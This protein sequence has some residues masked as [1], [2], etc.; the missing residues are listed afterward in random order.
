MYIGF[1]SHINQSPLNFLFISS[2][3]KFL[4]LFSTSF[5]FDSW[6]GSSLNILSKWTN[7]L[8][9]SYLLH[10]CKSVVFSSK[11]IFFGFAGSPIFNPPMYSI[12]PSVPSLEIQIKSYSELYPYFQD[13]VL[14]FLAITSLG[15]RFSTTS[16]MLFLYDLLIFNKLH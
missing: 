15:T 14:F 1:P 12:S 3:I 2:E 9:T 8:G 6:L 10:F 16:C 11:R 13:F 5:L 7:S 4:C